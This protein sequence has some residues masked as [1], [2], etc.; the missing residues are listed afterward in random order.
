VAS[1]PIKLVARFNILSA[2]HLVY[3]QGPRPPLYL[4]LILGEII[5]DLRSALDHLAWHLAIQHTEPALVARRG[6]M[7]AIQFPIS[8]SENALRNHR[9]M[10]YS[11]ADAVPKS[12]HCSLTTILSLR[13]RP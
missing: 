5:H 6:V 3:A 8:R 1:N 12:R 2:A 11:G 7:N 13:S 10:R 9:A 4:G